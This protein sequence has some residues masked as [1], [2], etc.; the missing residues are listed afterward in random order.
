MTYLVDTNILIDH[1]RGDRTSTEFLY[2][3]LEE[4]KAQAGISVITEY[5]LLAVPH[6]IL[7]QE[8]KIAKLLALMPRLA[9]TSKVARLAAEFRRRHQTNIADALI[10][11]TAHLRHPGNPQR[12]RLPAD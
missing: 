4:G 3:V 8:H 5:E 11:A 12:E 9:V 6:L 7:H 1:L 2:R 10:A